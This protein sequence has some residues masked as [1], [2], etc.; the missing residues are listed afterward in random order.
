MTYTPAN[1]QPDT[2][3]GE[4]ELIRKLVHLASLHSTPFP[5]GSTLYTFGD[6][7]TQGIIGVSTSW[8]PGGVVTAAHRWTDLL[9]AE[10]GQTLVNGG[11]SGSGY[12]YSTTNLWNRQSVTGRMGLLLPSATWTGTT[13]IMAG[14]NDILA[15]ETNCA[16]WLASYKQ[17]CVAA[18]ARALCSG[19][20]NIDGTTNTGTAQ[21]V[22]TTGTK[23]TEA[24]P[25]GNPFPIGTPATDPRRI[26][27]L[28]AGQTLSTTLANRDSAVIFFGLAGTT[29]GS[30]GTAVVTVNGV[31]VAEIN[32]AAPSWLLGELLGAVVL[33][34][35]PASA[36][37][38]ITGAT[39]SVRI[40]AVG[41]L[42]APSDALAVGRSVVIVSPA[43]FSS[44]YHIPSGLRLWAHAAHIAAQEFGNR[45]VFYAD[46]GAATEYADTVLAVG[47]GADGNHPSRGGNRK[48]V[49][50][51][52]GASRVAGSDLS[53]A[54]NTVE[55]IVSRNDLVALGSSGLIRGQVARLALFSAVAYL[56]S[57][58]QNSIYYPLEIRASRTS[59]P[60]GPLRL[61][62]LAAA[63]SSPLNGDMYYDTA[64]G[65]GRLREAGAWVNLV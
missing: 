14:Y 41:W 46:L 49:R 22:T 23:T 51:I 37:I 48:Y 3:D 63:P 32:S 27:A 36:P 19:Y 54:H 33:P 60:Q 11:I 64:L 26:C 62:N 1:A 45:R 16:E 28:A 52:R 25:E 53:G 5:R 13:V 4:M 59:I 21:T 38:V 20:V 40:H 6:S 50:V 35:I 24:F 9:A 30:G 15:N 58:D 42:P 10:T 56:D 39:G 47:E 44:T 17:T 2:N 31:Q 18:I 12:T 43:N 34:D 7:H 57:I 55:G 61:A 29:F 65:K 8:A